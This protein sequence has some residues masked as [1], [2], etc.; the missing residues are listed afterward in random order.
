MYYPNE[1]IDK[2]RFNY[3]ENLYEKM[4]KTIITYNINKFF[5]IR[6]KDL[7]I[8]LEK[9]KN[10][11][12]G[13][14]LEKIDKIHNLNDLMD[15][16]NDHKKDKNKLILNKMKNDSDPFIEIEEK[17]NSWSWGKNEC[18]LSDEQL[19]LIRISQDRE[20]KQKK[21]NQFKYRM[22]DQSG[23]LNLTVKKLMEIEKA[24]VPEEG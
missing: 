8:E 2:F 5:D 11:E 18:N 17:Y 7:T 19:K 1:L 12:T 22:M 3:G 21:L 10:K 23:D 4:K 24:D 20:D 16:Y 14:I 6:D 9:I 13:H 15:F